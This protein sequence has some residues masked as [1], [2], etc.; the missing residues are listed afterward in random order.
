MT[1]PG[2]FGSRTWTQWD[3]QQS[4]A[5]TQAP[6]SYKCLSVL[7]QTF[8]PPAPTHFGGAATM[9]HSCISLLPLPSVAVF[10]T[11][12]PVMLVICARPNGHGVR[13][14]C[15][16]VLGGRRDAAAPS[17]SAALS[18]GGATA[19]IQRRCLMKQSSARGAFLQA[20]VIQ[21]AQHLA[22]DTRC[23]QWPLLIWTPK[24]NTQWN[25]FGQIHLAFLDYGDILVLCI[26]NGLVYL[27]V[28]HS[29]F[30]ASLVTI[31]S[32][33]AF[34]YFRWSS[35]AASLQVQWSGIYLRTDKLVD[36]YV[37]CYCCLI[38]LNK[39][40]ENA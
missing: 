40:R 5:A 24:I 13:V 16:G 12:A 23:Q 26:N 15:R 31:Y 6:L 34:Y 27:K 17:V 39:Q 18:G 3:P 8:R 25:N 22:S 32:I 4:A 20:S 36:L 37:A 38:C 29:S 2:V 33:N 10:R 35:A 28:S 14:A 21:S 7:I 9:K 1:E 30:S 11:H 19:P